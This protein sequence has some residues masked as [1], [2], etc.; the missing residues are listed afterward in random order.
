M[1]LM[2][3][4]TTI[5]IGLLALSLAGVMVWTMWAQSAEPARPDTPPR[6]TRGLAP[7]EAETPMVLPTQDSGIRIDL[8]L[9]LWHI[10]T[11]L[12]VISGMW[13]VSLFQI[14]QHRTYHQKHFEHAGNDQA[15]WSSFERDSQRRTLD[16]IED[17]LKEM[18]LERGRGASGG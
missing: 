8:Q 9:Q 3:R 11:A 1:T 15:H 5:L 18:R 2:D 14:S 7:E 6:V 4:L 17:Q 16:R 10:L 12:V 13:F